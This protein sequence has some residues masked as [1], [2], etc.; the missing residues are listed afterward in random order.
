MGYQITAGEPYVSYHKG[1][2][3]RIKD[4]KGKG[5][6]IKTEHVKE[7]V[8]L[9]YYWG[10]YYP[11]KKKFGLFKSDELGNKKE[12]VYMYMPIKWE[13]LKCAEFE[14]LWYCGGTEWDQ[15]HSN[16]IRIPKDG[17][18]LT[19]TS[20]VHSLSHVYGKEV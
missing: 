12:R 9:R 19:S 4:V 3:P 7:G 1:Y 10:S 15:Q 17:F 16:Y 18:C 5:C 8:R 6:C 2:P 11:T 13:Y 20:T 14:T